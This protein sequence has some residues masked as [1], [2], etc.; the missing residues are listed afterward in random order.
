M[1][2][3][4]KE[5]GKRKSQRERKEPEKRKLRFGRSLMSRYMILILCAILFV[6]VVLPI[7]SIIYV[8][9]VNNTS[10]G[11]QAPYGDVTHI[12]NLWS[13]ESMKLDEAA[14]AQIDKRMKQLQAKYPKSSMYRVN[15]KGETAFILGGEG[16]EVSES[17]VNGTTMTILKWTL[18][19]Q[20]KEE[21]RIPAVWDV[22]ST[23][24]FMKEANYR[25]PLTV[26]SFIGG[27]DQNKGKGFMVIEVP[28]YLLQKPQSNWPME[29][30]YLG[31]VMTIIFLVFIVMSIL[32]FARIRKRLIRLQTAMITPGKEGIPLPVDIRRSD[33]IGQLEDSFNQMVY[34]L[35]DSRLREREEEQFRKRLIAGLSH[36][37]R[38]PLTVIRGHMHALNKE[39][40]SDKGSSSLARMEAKM[41]DLSGLIDNMLSY[42]LL[43]SGKY[44]LKLEEKDVLRIVRETAA[45][46][47]P[48]WEKEQFDIDIDLPD[49]PLIW[50]VDEQGMRRI[51]D[52]L[53]QNVI[54]YAGD[55]KYIGIS[56][57]R[58]Q[59]RTALVIRDKGP[60]MQHEIGAKGTG[61]GLSIVDLLVREMGLRKKVDS[62]PEGVRIFIY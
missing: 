40:L 43:A 61:L 5:K 3:R 28:R 62:S 39:A 30:L 11:S 26:V 15:E 10:K 34:Q 29:L 18:N 57:E 55:G 1:I 48:V 50:R 20:K 56:T 49:E 2:G 17:P 31:L 9:V 4:F 24:Q 54:R 14:P 7:T 47:Y 44:T 45:A 53:L 21:T 33:E 8:V 13:K 42:N 22:A 32:F 27:G 16:V 12:T 41:D 58:I 46:W 35:T 19:N 59:E 37:L 36:D 25:D 6:P 52:N 23:L 38:T 51:L 60:G